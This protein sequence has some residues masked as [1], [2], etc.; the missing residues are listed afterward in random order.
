MTANRPNAQPSNSHAQAPP[1]GQGATLF[2][3]TH[4]V[5]GPPEKTDSF[6]TAAQVRREGSTAQ[7]SAMEAGPCMILPAG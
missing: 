7:A 1:H 4:T 2:G 6:G 5:K 3:S